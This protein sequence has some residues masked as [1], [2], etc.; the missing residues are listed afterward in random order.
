MKKIAFL[1]LMIVSRN[2]FASHAYV[3]PTVFNEYFKN[4]EILMPSGALYVIYEKT[5]QSGD[6]ARC[7]R[8]H[9]RD[10]RILELYLG[11]NGLMPDGSQ[12]QVDARA[13]MRSWP[14]FKHERYS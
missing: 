7:V 2:F 3:V 8:T 14:K 11:Q 12:T 9:Y 13:G 1:C 10:G 5:N 4:K 6:V